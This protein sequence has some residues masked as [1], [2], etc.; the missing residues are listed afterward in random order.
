M[1]KSVVVLLAVS[2]AGFGEASPLRMGVSQTVSTVPIFGHN[3]CPIR[4][5]HS[6]KTL[7][8]PQRMIFSTKSADKLGVTG[9]LVGKTPSIA[10]HNAVKKK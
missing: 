6:Q 9:G 7:A 3:I 10:P 5:I 4:R 2:A 1:E 8:F